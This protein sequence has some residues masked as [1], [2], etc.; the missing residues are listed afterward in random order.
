[1]EK[2]TELLEEAKKHFKIADHLAYVTFTLLKENRLIIKILSELSVSASCLIKAF[3]YYEYAF[4]RIKISGDA[5]KNLRTFI[6]DVALKYM[7][8]E[9]LKNIIYILEVNKKHIDSHIEFVRKDKFV[10]LLGDKYE[11][12]DIQ[13]VRE[14]LHSTRSSIKSFPEIAN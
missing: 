1:M 3:L 11:T 8:G 10:I 6:S 5:Q 2:Y 9:D 12:L 4:K 13:R 14:L 7:S